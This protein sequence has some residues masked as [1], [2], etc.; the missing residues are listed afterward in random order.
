LP[1]PW[2]RARLRLRLSTRSL[3]VR[4]GR[5]GL[6]WSGDTPVGFSGTLKVI[7]VAS[8]TT[9][10]SPKFFPKKTFWDRCC[11]ADYGDI[12]LGLRKL[13][14]AEQE[15]GTA[16]APLG[17]ATVAGFEASSRTAWRISS[18]L[19]GDNVVDVAPDVLEIDRPMLLRSQSVAMVRRH[20]AGRN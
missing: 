11:H 2:L 13:V 1:L 20:L 5:G 10:V 7:R 12:E 14:A 8:L 6:V 18:S 17:S 4:I 9:L 3:A 15:A 19:N 16:T